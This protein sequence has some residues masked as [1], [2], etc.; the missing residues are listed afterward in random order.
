MQV[1]CE[2]WLAVHRSLLEPKERGIR[3]ACLTTKS[4][5]EVALAISFS[6]FWPQVTATSMVHSCSLPYPLLREKKKYI[7]Q[8]W[9][10]DASPKTHGRE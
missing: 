4:R 3:N 2:Q 8:A 5:H 6:M 10:K 1:I 9:E 7:N